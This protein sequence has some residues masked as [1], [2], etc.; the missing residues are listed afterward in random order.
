MLVTVAMEMVVEHLH[1]YILFRDEVCILSVHS[2]TWM[3]MDEMSMDVRS[4]CGMSTCKP[5]PRGR[6]KF[7][8]VSPLSFLGFSFVLSLFITPEFGGKKS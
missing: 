8:D 1:C 4:L 5:M 6:G 2:E 3:F 7:M